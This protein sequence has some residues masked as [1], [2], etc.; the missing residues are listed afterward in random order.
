MAESQVARFE[1]RDGNSRGAWLLKDIPGCVLVKHPEGW[2]L[3]VIRPKSIALS[4]M[5]KGPK[6]TW[7]EWWD[8]KAAID[9][10]TDNPE[11]A[12]YYP[13]RDQLLGV[14]KLLL[15]MQGR[16]YSGELK[17]IFA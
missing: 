4:V 9:F 3:E 5:G 2:R 8:H 15:E 14:I 1:D 6:E 16:E 12:R 11:M 13:T 10:K 7:G 17:D